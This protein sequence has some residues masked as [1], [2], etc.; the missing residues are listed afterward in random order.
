MR[1]VIQPVWN[2]PLVVVTII[3]MLGVLL[4]TYPRRV[5][6]LSPGWRRILIGL[7]LVSALI[8]IV[9]MLRPSIQISEMDHQSS[10][11]TVLLDQSRSMSTPDGAGDLTRRE[12][13]VQL[14]E[15]NGETL[16]AFRDEVDVQFLDFATELLPSSSLSPTADGEYTA[17][18]QTIDGLRENSSQDRLIGAILMSDGAQRAG[19]EADVDP[20]AAA[21]RFAEQLGVPIHTV[22]VGTSDVSGSGI[23]LAIEDMQLDQSVTFERKTVPVHLQVKLNGASG[24]EVRV[25]LLIEDRTGVADGESGEFREIPLSVD[26]TPFR[27]L[28]TDKNSLTI[29]VELSFVAERAGEY[30]IAAEVVPDPGEVKVNN[31]RR[32]TLI[33]VRKG[34]LKV[35]YFDVPRPEQKFLR[36]LND[37]AKIQVD[38]QVV[39]S[40][41]FAQETNIDP[42]LFSPGKYDVFIIGDVPASVFQKDGNKLLRELALRVNEGAG[43]IMIGGLHNFGAGGYA[44][45]PLATLLPVKMSP[46]EKI[47][48]DQENPDGHLQREVKFLP[49]EAGEDHY[50]MRLSGSQ[51]DSAWRRL[52][53]LGGANRLERKSGAV[54]VLAETETGD[55]LLLATD[56]GRARVL[57]LGVDETWK[58]HLRGFQAEHQRFWQQLILWLAHKEFDSDQP[59]WVRVEP[60]SY[61]PHMP[62]VIEFGAQNESGEAIPD[63]EYEVEVL[64]PS[65]ETLK[66]TPQRFGDHGIGEFLETGA[67]GDYWVRVSAKHNGASLGLLASTRFVVDSRDIEMDN[68]AADPGLMSEIASVSGGSVVPPENFGEFLTR[69]LDEGIPPEL[70]RYRTINLWDGWPPLI[71]FVVLMST[72]WVLR[73]KQGLV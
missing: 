31:N 28:K 33:T 68:P 62:V 4:W 11:L 37:T 50:L 59:V 36:R 15:E 53:L 13:L 41:R 12:V 58:W 23:D 51:N 63:A 54:E 3:V 32:E 61:A 65:G 29:P 46:D 35:A 43:L 20:L 38:T 72:E 18:G 17:I 6:H 49:T 1:F 70:K 16:E 22:T 44:D 10:R 40:G 69:L 26:A 45:T 42:D 8:L 55:P 34:G 66:V 14:V 60:R 5:R 30:K 57:A 47:R 67:P 7:R 39:L 71:L 21:R 9:A 56:T 19:G 25:R 48:I 24:K 73:K 52:P 64:M 27:D 2:W